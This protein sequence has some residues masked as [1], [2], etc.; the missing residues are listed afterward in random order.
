MKEEMLRRIRA[1]KHPARTPLPTYPARPSRPQQETTERFVEH[2]EDYKARVQRIAGVSQLPMA[3][4]RALGQK[5]KVVVPEDFPQE[6]LPEN[7]DLIRDPGTLSHHQ[8]KLQEVVI[9][10]CKLGIS[11]TGTLVLD[12]GAHQGRRV[13]S[14]IPDHHICIIFTDQIVQGVHD[15]VLQLESSVQAG[16]ALTWISGPS[17]TSDIELVRVEGVHG[18]RTLDVVLVG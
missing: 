13:I 2:V 9:T 1:A 7:L 4:R 18:P 5:Q 16:Q 12:S 6:W 14:L 8:I 17:A 11:D 3:I 10:G 15:A